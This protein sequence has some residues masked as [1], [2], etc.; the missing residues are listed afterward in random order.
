MISRFLAPFCLLSLWSAAAGLPAGETEVRYLSGR[1][2]DDALPWEF[3]CTAGPG[4]N[5][6]TTIPVPSCWE[7]HGF[8]AY[9]YQEDPLQEQGKYR[10]HFSVPP[11]WKGQVVRLVFEGVMTD[12]EVWINGQSAGPVHR[13]G[14][15]RFR[16]D[17][18]AL[19]N[20]GG[21]NLLEATVAKRSADASINAAERTGDYWNFGGIFRPVYL[22][23]LPPAY[24][25]RMAIDARADGSFRVEVFL[26]GKLDPA[27]QVSAQI[28][29]LT[30]PFTAPAAG[31]K[32]LLTA[33]VKEQKNWTAETP[34]LYRVLVTLDSGGQI[35]RSP[36]RF[37]FRTV[38]VRD[39]DGVYVNGQRI[40]LKGCCRHSF[41]PESGRTLSARLNREDILLL[42]QANMNAVRMS[43]YPPDA[44]FLDQ[45]D[46][47]GLY[48]LDE[49]AGW[50]KSYD[51]GVG[52]GFV[53]AMIQRDVNHPSILFWDN[54][55][56]G[57]W[58]T[59]LDGE[60]AKW[61]PQQRRVLHPWELCSGVNTKHYA[62]WETHQT[63]C[64][65]PDIYLPTEFLHGLYD[66]GAGAGLADYWELMRAGKAVAGG[67]LWA[68]LDEGVART[69]Q[70]CRIDA[71]GNRGPDGL[72]GPHREKKGSFFTV[73]E[74][75]S[76]VQVR[77]EPPAL[78]VENQYDFTGLQQCRFAW[79][80]GAFDL[81]KTGHRVIAEGAL[82]GPPVAPHGRGELRL[83]LPADWRQADVLY[84]SAHGPDERELWTWSWALR[85][86]GPPDV[87]A[88]VHAEV[89]EDEAG[90]TL[91]NGTLDLVFSRESGWLTR[92]GRFSFGRGPRFVASA[93]QQVQTGQDKNQ[94]PKFQSRTL[95]LSGASKL[96]SLSHRKDG[97]T[98]V[99]QA[100]FAGPLSQTE[101]QVLPGGWIKLSY[102]FSLGQECDLAGV[103]FDYPEHQVKSLRWLG[104]GPYRV[105][106]NRLQGTCWDVWETP[107]NNAIPGESWVYPE[108][109]GYFGDWQW[110]Q[111]ETT[112]GKITL[113]NGQEPG[114]LGV[115]RPVEGRT[116][117][118]TELFT[119]AT[120]L[121]L[122]E[123]IPPIGNKFTAPQKVGPQSQ[124]NPAPGTRRRTVYLKFD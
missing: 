114:Y 117:A 20:Y 13:G 60:F 77:G 110:A 67:F 47:L 5:A 16:Y 4:S 39:G 62:D 43:H 106:K 64:A 38:E 119:P 42:K 33:Q 9:G 109:K 100:N 79:K 63:L 81:G 7:L 69:D 44:D 90:L 23:A 85:R 17:V 54:G 19:L 94:K 22:E 1:G 15:Y 116:P 88:E 30:G 70:N 73:R 37:G 103:Q 122:L 35:H 98:A 2:K 68:F 124:P 28:E 40:T 101:W 45:C 108:F 56:E 121:A 46:E 84:L 75:W 78:T 61:D 53:E 57:G 51:A 72:V 92:A 83:P 49:L 87:P 36:A 112:E 113:I 105:W 3:L 50:Q 27:A 76:P 99:V 34:H 82:P 12:T 24:V 111:L 97:N 91:R 11:A 123:A 18:S 41:W 107:Y 52:R 32:A 96:L 120:G 115:Y 66:G 6:W 65:G 86:A 71:F 95:D 10:L 102:E 80:L 93:T 89:R 14:F 21:D 104:R 8:G 59:E 48:V 58:N 55:N 26:G 118:R 25:E 29:G 74:I 31:G